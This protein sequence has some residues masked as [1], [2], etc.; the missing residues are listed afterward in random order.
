MS[1]AVVT[2]KV[3]FVFTSL[4]AVIMNMKPIGIAKTC[5]DPI[6]IAHNNPA[7]ASLQFGGDGLVKALNAI[8]NPPIK[9]NW[10]AAIAAS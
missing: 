6:A 9:K 1:F 2:T 4:I 8:N 10:P 5:L 3:V 7:D